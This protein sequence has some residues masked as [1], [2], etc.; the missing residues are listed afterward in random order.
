MTIEELDAALI[1]MK[2]IRYTIDEL[3]ITAGRA[4]E[5]A[6]FVEA[7]LRADRL[8]SM[9]IATPALCQRVQEQM[10]PTTYMVT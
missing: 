9:E 8:T 3:Q 5:F 6:E 4:L 2:N 7:R 10:L 1:E